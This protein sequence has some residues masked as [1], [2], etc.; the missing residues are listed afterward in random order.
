LSLR[1]LIRLRTATS[2]PL[3][4]PV[5]GKRQNVAEIRAYSSLRKNRTY[6]SFWPVPRL[7]TGC[8]DERRAQEAA[9]TAMSWLVGQC[10][11]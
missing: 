10:A 7:D 4:S 2:V 6:D 8:A 11:R 5:A 1:V 3:D 9:I